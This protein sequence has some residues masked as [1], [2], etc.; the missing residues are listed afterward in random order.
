MIPGWLGSS[1]WLYR[2]GP[3]GLLEQVRGSQ[4]RDIARFSWLLIA[5]VLV[6]SKIELSR[7]EKGKVMEF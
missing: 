6:E 2:E 1:H 7:V 3:V 5:G 4:T